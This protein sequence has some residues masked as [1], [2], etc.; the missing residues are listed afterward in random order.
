M[1]GH[2]CKAQTDSNLGKRYIF[3]LLIKEE[4]MDTSPCF[5]SYFVVLQCDQSSAELELKIFN[6]IIQ[7]IVIK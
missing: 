3:E 7:I 4:R 1:S 6:Q 2:M 5:A